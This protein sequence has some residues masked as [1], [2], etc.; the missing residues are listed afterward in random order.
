MSYLLCFYTYTVYCSHNRSDILN[1][2][3]THLKLG[4]NAILA[5]SLAVCKAGAMVKKIP[6]YQ[7]C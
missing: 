5:V 1:V 2:V 4:A 6:L 3:L 7:V